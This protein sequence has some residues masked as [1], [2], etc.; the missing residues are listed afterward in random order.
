MTS[1]RYIN[2]RTTL[3]QRWN[4]VEMFAGFLIRIKWWQSFRFDD[5]LILLAD[6]MFLFCPFHCQNQCYLKTLHRVRF[7]LFDSTDFVLSMTSMHSRREYWTLA[8]HCLSVFS[9]CSRRLSFT[10]FYNLKVGFK[11]FQTVIQIFYFY[12]QRV[13]SEIHLILHFYEKINQVSLVHTL[14][15]FSTKNVTQGKLNKNYP[16][17]ITSKI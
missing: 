14:V 12:Y 11:P 9:T 15:I 17:N 8:K 2:L 4:N 6:D 10:V 13:S 3:K 1:R 16:D 5:D 7:K